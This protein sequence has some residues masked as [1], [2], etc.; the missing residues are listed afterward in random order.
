MII[1]WLKLLYVGKNK[2]KMIEWLEKQIKHIIN[3]VTS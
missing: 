1:F 3:I 2:I